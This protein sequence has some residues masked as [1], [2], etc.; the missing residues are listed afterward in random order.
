MLID[1]VHNPDVLIEEIGT[2]WF[3][4]CDEYYDNIYRHPKHPETVRIMGCDE[5]V[6]IDV[7]TEE[8][9]KAMQSARALCLLL[10]QLY[11]VKE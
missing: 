1:C 4:V 6:L 8:F 5:T 2:P 11:T 9:G 3:S 10:N 7:T